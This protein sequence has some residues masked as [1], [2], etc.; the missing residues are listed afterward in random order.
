[1]YGLQMVK[2]DFENGVIRVFSEECTTNFSGLV[3]QMQGK[4]ERRI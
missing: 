1:M 4:F 3:Q 2:K